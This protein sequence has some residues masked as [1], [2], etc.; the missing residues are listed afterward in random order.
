MCIVP[1]NADSAK[2]SLSMHI[3]RTL[4]NRSETQSAKLLIFQLA[5][6]GQPAAIRV[7]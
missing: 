5:P 1:E 7:K 3:H 6:N 4:R 2:E